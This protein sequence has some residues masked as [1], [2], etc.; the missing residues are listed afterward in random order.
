MLASLQTSLH[1][2]GLGIPL[3]HPKTSPDEDLPSRTRCVAAISAGCSPLL[4]T[5]GRKLLKF[6]ASLAPNRGSRSADNVGFAWLGCVA[7]PVRPTHELGLPALQFQDA[8]HRVPEPA[9]QHIHCGFRHGHLRLH[10]QFALLLLLDQA[11]TPSTQRALCLQTGYTQGKGEGAEPTRD[12]R[13]LLGG[14]QAQG[15]AGD[16]S[17]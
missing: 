6:T 13:R 7:A 16:L 9:S 5:S 10:P 14:V 15:R 12:L 1:S 17:L 4:F 2:T 11:Q 3:F 8:E